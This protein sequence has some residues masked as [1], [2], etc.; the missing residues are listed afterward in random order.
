VI[1][2]ILSDV[3]GDPIDV[4]AS[5]PWARN[6]SSPENAL[7]ILLELGGQKYAP[8]IVEHLQNLQ[9]GSWNP[10]TPGKNVTQEIVGSNK[11]ALKEMERSLENQGFHVISHGSENSGYARDF[12]HLLADYAEKERA[13][14]TEGS[15]AVAHI[16]GGETIVD[17]RSGVEDRVGGGRNQRIVLS[18]LEKVWSS[19]LKNVLFFSLG[20]DGEDGRGPRPV[21]GAIAGEAII[22]KAKEKGLSPEY[23]LERCDEFPFFDSTGGHF[24]SGLSGTNVCDLSGFAIW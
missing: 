6:T 3:L 12:G 17:L 7:D 21:A 16:F 22:S 18:A 10:P 2:L 13:L 14:H 19:E 15:Q 5:G 24:E 8:E 9:T 4:I 1:A 20:T 11:I 23:Y